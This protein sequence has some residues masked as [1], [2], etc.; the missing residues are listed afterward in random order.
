VKKQTMAE[1]NV[2]DIQSIDVDVLMSDV[3]SNDA[4]PIRDERFFQVVQAT[5]DP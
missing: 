1:A 5:W 4:E 3:L 2:I